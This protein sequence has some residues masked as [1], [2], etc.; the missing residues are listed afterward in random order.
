M[1]QKNKGTKQQIEIIGS[2]APVK[3][4]IACAGSG[5]TWVLTNSIAAILEDKKCGPGDILALTF[6]KNAAENMRTRIGERLKD[7]DN[8]N[9]MDIYT[10][11]SFG[12]DIIYEN[13]FELGLG[14]DFGL[15]SSSQSWQILYEILKGFSFSHIRIGKTPAI[16]LQKLLSFIEDL[17][18]NLISPEAFYKYISEHEKILASY[19]SKALRS[20]EE[21]IIG[22]SGELF[23][24]YLKYEKIKSSRNTIDYQDQ[25]FMPYFLLAK[26]KALQ[27][28]YRLKYKYIFIDEFQDTNIAQAQLMTLLY[29]KG[30]N[31]IMIVG[32]DDQG[33]YSF[34]G[35]CIDN[36]LNFDKWDCFKD[37]ET[38]NF[39]L[40]T[41]FRSGSG[42]IDSVHSVISRNKNRFKKEFKAFDKNKESLVLFDI[43]RTLEEEA[44]SLVGHIEKIIL[45]GG[46]KLRDMAIISRRKRFDGIVSALKKANIKYELIGGRNFYHEPEVLFIISWLKVI[47]NIFDEISITYILKSAKYRIGDRD[48]FFL[49][50]GTGG[51]CHAG[52]IDAIKRC[53]SN[54]LLSSEARKRFRFFLDSLLFYI[55][56]SRMLD[57]KELIS[58]IFEDSGLSGQLRA[59]FGAPA[60]RKTNNIENLI[61]IASDFNE[62]YLDAGLDSFITYLKDIAKTD[63]DNPDKIEISRENSI[64]LMSIHA[65][66]GLEFEAVFLPILWKNDY[67]GKNS[68][69]GGFVIPSELRKDGSIWNGK[70]NYRSARSFKNDLK[71]LKI[72]EERRIFYVACSRAKKILV[73]SYSQFEDTAAADDAEN[74]NKRAKEIVPFFGDLL[75]KES[76]LRPLDSR[77]KEFLY[78]LCP[79]IKTYK[80]F[81]MMEM[82]KMFG[83]S[84]DNKIINTKHIKIHNW[85][86]TEKKLGL[87]VGS[88]EKS[89]KGG[90]DISG[91]LNGILGSPHKIHLSSSVIKGSRKYLDNIRRSYN[92]KKTNIGS[93]PDIIAANR[94][95]QLLFSL[96]PVLDYLECP[97]MYKWRYV[98]SIPQRPDKKMIRGELIHKYIEN[99]TCLRFEDP[100]A[101]QNFSLQE[102]YPEEIR[103]YL[104]V[105][106]KSIFADLS[107]NRPEKLMLEQLFYYRVGEYYVTGKLDR[108]AVYL[109]GHAEIVDYKMSGQK[110]ENNT[111]SAGHIPERYR[112]QLMTYI[113]A[114]SDILRT[115]PKDIKGLLLYLGNGRIHSVSGSSSGI[116]EIKG[117]LSGAIQHIS[118]GDF[119]TLKETECRKDCQ[120][121]K[122]CF[123]K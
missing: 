117:I 60:K 35:A 67:L 59:A 70:K 38:K 32:D 113:G 44:Q 51:S 73:L 21:D 63:Y 28:K 26:R 118:N 6:T 56:R 53:G 34:R 94:G 3:R 36:I 42:I 97:S 52:I 87:L 95:D 61:R 100:G 17:K 22:L 82:K 112:Q 119:N 13:S 39:F 49:K 76:H 24:I 1:D 65:A 8:I 123:D 40:S 88:M 55:G 96:T 111:G 90:Q 66:K 14:K 107:L 64:K 103:P 102:Y 45:Y 62:S 7:P 84:R 31:N 11:N 27:E 5:K 86:Q 121:F 69:S 114:A 80:C 91:V 23:E 9:S 120:Y 109:D 79:D 47:N 15:I 92:K 108:V 30:Y 4:V 33:I 19:K 85:K 41:N 37:D 57:L 110:M 2:D 98:Y 122:L 104:D 116:D 16:F 54:E 101:L 50:N 20:G 105:F 74:N 58:L 72:E 46:I 12:N 78:G 75:K 18:N 115:H 29:K 81:D 83:E 77:A 71:E 93:Y 25:V 68:G 48:I 99:S 43:N 106:D 10:F 89:L